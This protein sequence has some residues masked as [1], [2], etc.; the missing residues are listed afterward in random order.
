MSLCR[1]YT[2]E[3]EIRDQRN[4]LAS[5]MLNSYQWPPSGK[6]TDVNVDTWLIFGMRWKAWLFM[7]RIV[8]KPLWSPMS[9]IGPEDD[10]VSSRCRINLYDWIY[11]LCVQSLCLFYLFSSGS[12]VLCAVCRHHDVVSF[13]KLLCPGVLSLFHNVQV[14]R[15]VSPSLYYSQYHWWFMSTFFLVSACSITWVKTCIEMK[16]L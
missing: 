3:F 1:E 2:V 15:S 6:L 13:R 16:I 9:Y 4:R 7:T 10:R 12:S 5:Q 8:F 14:Q 11:F